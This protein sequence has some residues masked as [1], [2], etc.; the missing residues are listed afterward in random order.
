MTSFNKEDE[1]QTEEW[2]EE[3]LECIKEDF[4]FSKCLG[5]LDDLDRTSFGPF[6]DSEGKLKV[7]V[8]VQEENAMEVAVHKSTELVTEND[9]E[10]DTGEVDAN[11]IDDCNL[12]SS[13][14]IGKYVFSAAIFRENLI[15]V[16]TSEQDLVSETTH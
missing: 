15:K 10:R 13:L 2:D 6:M 1:N 5:S 3:N 7:C 9:E 12:Q 14:S 8:A 16:S 4:E 11:G